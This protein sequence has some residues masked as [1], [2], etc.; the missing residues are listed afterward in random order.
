MSSLDSLRDDV[1]SNLSAALDIGKI[2]N[3]FNTFVGIIKDQQVK[4]DK[5][6]E[7]I[8]DLKDK[9]SKLNVE[10]LESLESKLDE[11]IQEIKGGGD[12]D[13]SILHADISPFDAFHPV[14]PVIAPIIEDEEEDDS[15]IESHPA[16]LPRLEEENSIAS[17]EKDSAQDANV[18]QEKEDD[19]NDFILEDS[20][21]T[22]PL[23]ISKGDGTP[24]VEDIHETIKPQ[25]QQNANENS[26]ALEIPNSSVV[27]PIDSEERQ[28]SFSAVFTPL[29]GNMSFGSPTKSNL[30]EESPLLSRV[31]SSE[32]AISQTSSARPSSGR[33]TSARP[34]RAASVDTGAMARPARSYSIV[35]NSEQ[36]PTDGETPIL[37]EIS[38]T[39]PLVIEALKRSTNAGPLSGRSVTM[40][41]PLSASA[42]ATVSGSGIP[43]PNGRPPSGVP[44]RPLSGLNSGRKHNSVVVRR[45]MDA[46]RLGWLTPFR[47]K[48]FLKALRMRGRFI[49]ISRRIMEES[50]KKYG[51]A[52]LKNRIDVLE[53][54]LIRINGR[55]EAMKDTMKKNHTAVK[56]LVSPDVN[57]LLEVMEKFV[58]GVNNGMGSMENFLRIV[59]TLKDANLSALKEMG[60][61]QMSTEKLQQSVAKDIK[62]QLDTKFAILSKEYVSRQEV[63]N[64]LRQGSAVDQNMDQMH[65]KLL[66]LIDRTVQPPL[67]NLDTLRLE[68]EKRV[69]EKILARQNELINSLET[70]QIDT[71]RDMEERLRALVQQVSF[72]AKRADTNDRIDDEFAVLKTKLKK[73]EDDREVL[74]EARGKEAQQRQAEHEALKIL[75]R[76]LANISVDKLMDELKDVRE[77]I[78]DRPSTHQVEHMVGKIEKTFKS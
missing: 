47:A 11:F 48:R 66:Q 36:R 34:N 7:E 77:E 33:P 6:G 2:M 57:K 67:E 32:E 16:R 69:Q 70:Q 25:V 27:P 31:P 62:E 19:S 50:R 41:R 29:T 73:L 23:A 49:L 64:M 21:P 58:K 40:I 1:A 74:A 28:S 38:S 43:M 78:K 55:M 37:D 13:K 22:P 24:T 61:D 52:S 9:M 54:D 68:G 39:L 15:T 72:L 5:T 26:L 63:M 46:N 30:P 20:S 42:S 4:L 56:E 71:Q 75:Q 8:R 44:S 12:M 35:V 53:A 10:H 3:V 76:R 14:N 45:R 51:A 60:S 17:I 59:L 65:L 18:I